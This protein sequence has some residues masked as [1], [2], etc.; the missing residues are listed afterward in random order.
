MTRRLSTGPLA[1]LL[2]EAEDSYYDF[3]DT[4]YSVDGG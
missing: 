4:A 1:V 3:N 2:F